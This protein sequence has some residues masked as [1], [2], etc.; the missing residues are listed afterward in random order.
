MD[1]VDV[2]AVVLVGGTGTRLRPLTEVT[3]KPLL[4]AAGE[5]LVAHLVARL[6]GIG[7]QRVVLATSYRAELFRDRFG[8]G[9]HL[10]VEL[11]YAVETE[12]LGTGGAIRHAA[13]R[14]TL[15]GDV[16]VLNGD[17][18]AG[19][20]LLALL[21]EHRRAG[22]DVTLVLTEVADPRAFG[23]VPTTPDGRVQAFLEKPAGTQEVPTH[24]VNAGCYVFTP[25]AIQ[26]IPPRRVVSVERET[27]P[28]LLRQGRLVIGRLDT[29]YWRDL[30]TPEQFA[31]GSADLVRGVVVSPL[32]SGRTG[33]AL[34]LPDAVVAADAR[35]SGG[36]T[37]GRA[38]VVGPGAQVAGS[39]VFDG[40]RIGAGALVSGSLVGPGAVLGDGCRASGAV[41][42]AGA[43][44]GERVT[45]ARGARVGTGEPVTGG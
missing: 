39:V 26:E 19:T 34:I 14:L 10:G 21:E 2:E 27:F 7:V 24:Q 31:A 16:L 45:L 36:T 15:A 20:D 18:L 40:A 43:V 6:R 30:G 23:L 13:A 1:R 25:A 3:P 32:L 35:L 22:A 4:E 37:I 44:I 38:A 28:A 41:I 33:E 8:A 5:P 12:P 17:V 9:E 29:G 42:G 11:S